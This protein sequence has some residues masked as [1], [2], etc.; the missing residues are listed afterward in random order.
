[1][2]YAG[3]T[4][5]ESTDGPYLPIIVPKQAVT[6][7]LKTGSSDMLSFCLRKS[8]KQ[9]KKRYYLLSTGP[10][11]YLHIGFEISYV[12]E[13]PLSILLTISNNYYL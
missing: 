4:E 2:F 12:T 10:I 8:V 1:M 3:K 6:P 5:A 7:Y 11:G 9:K 13:Q